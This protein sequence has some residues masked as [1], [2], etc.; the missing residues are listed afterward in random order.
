[1]SIINNKK[2]NELFRGFTGNAHNVIVS[3]QKDAIKSELKKVAAF[4]E[5]PDGFIESKKYGN[6]KTDWFEGVM[7]IEMPDGYKELNPI[8]KKWVEQ[9]GLEIFQL[10]SGKRDVCIKI[11]FEEDTLRAIETFK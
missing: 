7:F 9:L 11:K 3:V 5:D 4:Y 8:T 6:P 10:S 1:M 2:L